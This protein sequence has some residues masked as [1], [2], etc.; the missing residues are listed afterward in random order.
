MSHFI[1]DTITDIRSGRE[2][3]R[4]FTAFGTLAFTVA[5]AMKL[6]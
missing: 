3:W 6:I 5:I 1:Q 4:I 2:S